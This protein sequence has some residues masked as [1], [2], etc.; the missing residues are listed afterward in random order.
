MISCIAIVPWKQTTLQSSS[1][2]PS[3]LSETKANILQQAGEVDSP[4][5]EVT[6]MVEFSGHCQ[7]SE[8]RERSRIVLTTDTSLFGWG[9]HLQYQIAQG[10]WS[11]EDLKH[12]INWLELRAIHLALCHFSHKVR[13][14]HV[15][16]LNGQHSSQSPC[17]SSRGNQVKF[18]DD[19]SQT[20]LFLGRG[21]SSLNQGG[22]HLGVNQS[23]G[24]CPQQGDGG[25]FSVASGSRAVPGNI[26]QSGASSSG[27]VHLSS[28]LPTPKI[29]FPIPVT[30]VGG[31]RCSAHTVAPGPSLRFSSVPPSSGCHPQDSTREG[32]GGSHSSSLA[33]ASVVRQS[34]ESVSI[35]TVEDTSGPSNTQSRGA[36][37]PR[38]SMATV[39]RMV[40]ERRCLTEEAYPRRVIDMIQAS[41]RSST[42]RVYDST[43]RSFLSW[44]SSI[45]S[46]CHLSLCLKFYSFYW[47][48]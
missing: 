23:A 14:Q 33:N 9:A 45:R 15:L 5:I 16:V 20:A 8:F 36:P 46:S 18:S 11:K 38:P 19:G 4:G 42:N 47:M 7:G 48:E 24:R 43:W 3:P 21:Q 27:F 31:S 13:G 30:G 44:M 32:G 26:S 29:F 25:S 41:R 39:D 1:V 37:A 10:R 34:H 40:L 22:S 28:E 35:G 17:E 12:N 6:Q 2:V